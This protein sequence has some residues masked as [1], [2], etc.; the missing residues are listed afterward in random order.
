MQDE[1]EASGI[2]RGV[3][4]Q[5]LEDG[6]ILIRLPAMQDVFL[7][8][9][10]LIFALVWLAVGW[11][12]AFAKHEAMGWIPL[13]LGLLLSWPALYVAFGQVEIRLG[14]DRVDWRRILFK[15]G[16]WKGVERSEIRALASHVFM[17][18]NG[19]PTSWALYWLAGERKAGGAPAKAFPPTNLE[20]LD[21]T[22]RVNVAGSF[23]EPA[24]LW[25]G[26]L[27][28]KWAGLTFDTNLDRTVS[29][30]D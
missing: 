10:F 23:K 5:K 30:P 16:R 22:P 26:T 1:A 9:F 6:S 17:R 4:L 3:R 24:A 11:A 21:K 20:F 28:G 13:S 25:L 29:A 27:L 14:P 12:L 2:P 7:A 15:P 19:K 8:V 18:T